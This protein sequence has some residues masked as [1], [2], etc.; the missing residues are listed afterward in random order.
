MKQWGIMFRNYKSELNSKWAKKGLD[1]TKRYK[2][3]AGQWAV[4]LEQRSTE[5]FKALSESKSELA[6]RNKY[7]HHLGTG[8]YQRKLAQWEQEDEAQ[9]AKGLPALPD[10]LGR[11]GSRWIRARVPAKE[12]KSGLSFS[13]PMV[14]EATKNIFQWQLSNKRVNLSLKGRGMSLLLLWVTQSILVVYEA[15]HQKILGN[16]YNVLPQSEYQG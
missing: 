6:R 5:E 13:D 9:R 8:G 11:R 15:S 2:I 4:F 12:A 10:Q 3:T 7:H 14:E 16:R 1:P